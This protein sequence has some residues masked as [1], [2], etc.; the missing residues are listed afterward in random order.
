M[1]PRACL[2]VLEK[3]KVS[4]L[5][6][7]F[8]TRTVQPVVSSF[9]VY[10]IPAPNRMHNCTCKYIISLYCIHYVLLLVDT[11]FCIVCSVF[12]LFRLYT[13]ILICFVCTSAIG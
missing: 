5:I 3:Q 9:T 8:E 2:E 12:V 13:F 11:M 4:Y 6:P 1:R 10:N 7:G